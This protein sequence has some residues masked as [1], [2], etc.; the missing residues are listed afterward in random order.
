VRKRVVPQNV[1]IPRIPVPTPGYPGVC[2]AGIPGIQVVPHC[3]VYAVPR[4]VCSRGAYTPRAAS[5]RINGSPGWSSRGA[6]G[7]TARRLPRGAGGWQWLAHLT[8]EQHTAS[9]QTVTTVLHS[10]RHCTTPAS[11]YTTQCAD[12][13][14]HKM[15]IDSRNQGD[16]TL[17]GVRGTSGSL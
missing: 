12:A 6:L 4:G 5:Y 16:T 14:Y 15:T 11:G 1:T 9:S 8:A 2:I 7:R 10:S 17:Q 13:P 3:R